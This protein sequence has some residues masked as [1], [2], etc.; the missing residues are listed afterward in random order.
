MAG[1]SLS[2]LTLP[3]LDPPP[4]VLVVVAPYY[5]EI[6][7]LL[8]AGA[9]R[10]LDRAGAKVSLVE[11]PG[12]L[13]IPPAIRLAGNSHRFQ[14]Y[15]AL[16]CVIRGAT[17][18]YDIVAGE[19]A[20]GL[21]LLGLDGHPVGNG[22]LTVDTMDQA[23]ARAGEQDKGGGAAEACLHLVALG[24]RFRG[25]GRREEPLPPP[26]QVAND[27]ADPTGRNRA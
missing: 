6:A 26:V 1:E 19:S 23:R 21:M 18:H 2:R 10:V 7:D 24:R 20:R 14:G 25:G 16:G 12:A 15:V 27:S 11:V 3:A 9:R 8:L 4:A 17:S 5:R 22:I 13:E